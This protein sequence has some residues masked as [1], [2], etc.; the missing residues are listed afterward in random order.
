MMDFCKSIRVF[1]DRKRAA[2][3]RVF[4]QLLISTKAN[5]LANITATAIYFEC[6]QKTS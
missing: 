6:K 4:K 5:L 3:N 2:K 1:S